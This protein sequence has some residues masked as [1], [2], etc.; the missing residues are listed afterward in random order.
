MEL[1]YF[2]WKVNGNLLVI[3]CIVMVLYKIK[4]ENVSEMVKIKIYGFKE[5]WFNS[6]LKEMFKRML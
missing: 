2:I 5:K 1:Y 3:Y 6:V 4:F